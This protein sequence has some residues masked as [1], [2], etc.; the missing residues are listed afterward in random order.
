[1]NIPFF[2]TGEEYCKSDQNDPVLRSWLKLLAS[3]QFHQKCYALVAI[4]VKCTVN[5]YTY[6][7]SPEALLQMTIVP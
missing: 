1:M 4:R 3:A 7:M 5:V 2:Q 6:V